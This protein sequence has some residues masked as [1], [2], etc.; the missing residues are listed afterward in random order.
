M[1]PERP[2][3]DA[4]AY[5]KIK[6]GQE[7]KPKITL[8]NK[9]LETL[10]VETL[11]KLTVKEIEPLRKLYASLKDRLEDWEKLTGHKLLATAKSSTRKTAKRAR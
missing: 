10:T 9:A 8:A 5:V 3:A 7:W 2:L 4:I 6:T 1:D 11:K